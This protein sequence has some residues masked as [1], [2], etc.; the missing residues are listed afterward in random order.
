MK[1]SK[2]SLTILYRNYI[3]EAKDPFIAAA[4]KKIM[5]AVY[6]H[7]GFT[8][9]RKVSH[10][11]LGFDYVIQRGFRNADA[12]AAITSYARIYI[13]NI[14]KNN[15]LEIAYWNTDVIFVTKAFPES[16]VP[17]DQILGVLRVVDIITRVL[18]LCL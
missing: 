2:T 9:V 3:R 10:P 16:L 5:N 17:K 18:F 13:Y 15:N 7:I 14:I 11:I 8:E 1:E 4:F 6:G 12:A